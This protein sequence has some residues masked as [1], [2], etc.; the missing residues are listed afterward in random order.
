MGKLEGRTALVTGATSGIGRG[1]AIA[2]AAEG[3]RVAV[4]YPPI[5]GQAEAAEGVC[6]EIRESGGKA[7]AVAAD[8]SDAKAVSAMVAQVEAA[9][10]PVDVLANVAGI[11]VSAPLEDIDVADWDRVIAVHLKGTFLCTQAVLP[12]MYQRDYGKIINTASQ[13][14][15]K[16]APRFRHY[17]AA[18]GGILALTRTLSLE[19]GAR[20]VNANVVAPVRLERRWWTVC[21]QTSS[22]LSAPPSQGAARRGRRYRARL[23]VPGVGRRPPLCRPVP[24]AQWWGRVPVS[25]AERGIEAAAVARLEPGCFETLRGCTRLT[26]RQPDGHP[27]I[28]RHRQALAIL[29]RSG[30]LMP[31]LH[32]ALR[33]REC[34]VVL[35][36]HWR[37][38]NG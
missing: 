6:A 30:D 10:G 26:H 32:T 38:R 35:V 18:K 31:W 21:Q 34:C 5:A 29:V 25:P 17:T 4:N 8:V 33:G 9:L 2:Y 12:G 37:T 1:V 36:R 24:D 16:G 13:L 3:A 20:N 11:A 28:A 15:Y 27:T 14:A 23:R 22:R 19:I 7:L